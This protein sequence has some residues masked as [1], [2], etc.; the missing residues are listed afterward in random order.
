MIFVKQFTKLQLGWG[1]VTFF[2]EKIYAVNKDS[3]YTILDCTDCAKYH[4]CLRRVLCCYNLHLPQAVIRNQS[5]RRPGS[6]PEPM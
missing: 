1:G 4:V 2:S 6:P 5:K 3:T